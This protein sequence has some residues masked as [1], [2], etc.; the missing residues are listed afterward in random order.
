MPTFLNT[1]SLGYDDVNLIAQSQRHIVS[2]SEIPVE[3]NRVIVAPMQSVVGEKFALEALRL[4]L[5]VCMPRFIGLEKQKEIFQKAYEENKKYTKRL[6]FSFGLNNG[7]DDEASKLAKEY[8]NKYFQKTNV[9]LDVANGYLYQCKKWIR[10]VSSAWPVNLMV[11]NIHSAKGLNLYA[12]GYDYDEIY[13]RVGIGQGSVCKTSTVSGF[14]RG[15]ITEITE[16]YRERLHKQLIVAD[17][18]IKQSGDAVK[19]FGAGADFAMMSGYFS[20][21]VEAQNILDGEYSYWGGASH[22]QQIKERGEI[23]RHSEGAVKE[24]NKENIRPLKDLVSDLWGGIASGVSYSGYKSLSDFIGNG[25][26][27][28]KK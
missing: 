22:K 20:N 18:G 10:F 15:Q 13:V 27:E 6:W 7:S 26:F 3:L 4:G 2:R 23:Y 19:A 21:A 28:V 8:E 11:G 5:Q 16:C 14:T 9:L 1:T 25:V 17:G 12:G 24:V